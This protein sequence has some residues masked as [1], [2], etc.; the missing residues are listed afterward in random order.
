MIVA[1][2]TFAGVAVFVV[3]LVLFAI[4]AIFVIR[5][6]RRL[7]RRSAEGDRASATGRTTGDRDEG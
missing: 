5:F 6:A 7:G 4:L 1:N 3:F 2:A